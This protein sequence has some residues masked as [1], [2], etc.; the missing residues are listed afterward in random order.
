MTYKEVINKNSARYGLYSI[1]D[2]ENIWSTRKLNKLYRWT[3][4]KL[5]EERLLR[6]LSTNSLELIRWK[7]EDNEVSPVLVASSI[8]NDLTILWITYY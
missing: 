6:C 2:N 5:D 1:I 4:K 3:I 8:W 7:L